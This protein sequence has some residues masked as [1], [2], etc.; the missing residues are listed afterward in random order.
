MNC[1]QPYSASSLNRVLGQL[2]GTSFHSLP[3]EVKAIVFTIHCLEDNW[4][5]ELEPVTRTT[6][7]KAHPAI[8]LS[9]IC[10]EWRA[11]SLGSPRLWTRF[12]LPPIPTLH[13]DADLASRPYIPCRGTM[14]SS[15]STFRGGGNIASGLDRPVVT[16]ATIDKLERIRDM[17]E[18]WF[19]RSKSLPL[20][21][22]YS[23]DYISD[24]EMVLKL[25]NGR[26]PQN[27]LDDIFEARSRLRGILCASFSRWTDV[28]IVRMHHCIDAPERCGSLMALTLLELI[29]D[30]ITSFPL[31]PFEKL[32]ELLRSTFEPTPEKGD[33]LLATS[34]VRSVTIGRKS[35]ATNFEYEQQVVCF[36]P[37]NENYE[38]TVWKNLRYLALHNT[39]TREVAQILRTLALCQSIIKLYIDFHPVSTFSSAGEYSSY[40]PKELEATME[41]LTSMTLSGSPPFKDIIK[42][43]K[44]PALQYLTLENLV[45]PCNDSEPIAECEFEDS[46]EEW[47]KS[48]GSGLREFIISG[49]T[50]IGRRAAAFGTT[51]SRVCRLESKPPCQ[52]AQG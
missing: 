51:F 36:D 13:W 24:P 18:I 40:N 49:D 16:E 28:N 41:H 25:C 15:L 34:H 11:I 23:A 20:K 5:E 7:Y 2:D 37:L 31:N 12:L 19:S 43:V 50:H 39:H 17:C 29:N 45:Y 14:F 21:I 35:G 48:V 38:R 8:H 6:F 3:V 47:T 46:L 52:P 9:H 44:F 10:Q 30:E 1:N 22:T 42:F 33:Q 27:L 32:I 26:Y 4:Y